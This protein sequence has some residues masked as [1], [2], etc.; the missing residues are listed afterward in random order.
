MPDMEQVLKQL[1]D[2]LAVTVGIQDHHARMILEHAK[3]LEDNTRALAQHRAWLQQHE[4]AM[5]E[6]ELAM[7]ALD[8]KLDRLA[9]LILRGRGGNGESR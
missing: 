7:R 5:Q 4:A 9:D 3:W 8:T 1:Q 2:T 6:H